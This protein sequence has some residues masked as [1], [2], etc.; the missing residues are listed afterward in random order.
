MHAESIVCRNA[1]QSGMDWLWAS[2]RLLVG[3]KKL[4]LAQA[5]ISLRSS[6]RNI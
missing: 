1:Q 6:S 3:S 2:I 5:I 4:V